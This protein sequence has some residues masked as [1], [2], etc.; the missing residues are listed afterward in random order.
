M[1]ILTNPAIQ[2]DNKNIR[3]YWNIDKHALMLIVT[4]K[5]D[6]K[7]VKRKDYRPLIHKANKS[8]ETLKQEFSR[9]IRGILNVDF[10]LDIGLDNTN[11]LINAIFNY[12]TV[13]K[14]ATE[15]LEE[16][17]NN[18][19]GHIF[20]EV[21]QELE[22]YNL[23][24]PN[25][26]VETPTNDNNEFDLDKILG[27]TAKNVFKDYINHNHQKEL[28]NIDHNVNLPQTINIDWD[29]LDIF[30]HDLGEMVINKPNDTLELMQIALAELTT[31]K[32][33][34]IDND[35]N[36][37][38]DNL[39]ITPTKHL[40]ASK[41]GQMVQTEGIIKGILEP[42]FYYKTAVFECKGCH[43]W[44]EV[45]QK[46]NGILEPSLC[47]ECGGRSFILM[48]E[49]STAIDL[50]YIRLQEPTEDLDTDERPRNILVC[51]TGSLSHNIVN[52]QRVKI[53][54]ILEGMDEDGNRKFVLNA[55]NIVNVKDTKIE[56]TDEDKQKIISLSKKDNILDILINS[57]APKIILPREVKLAVLCYLVK[58]GYTEDLRQEIHLLFIG[59]PGTAKTKLKIIA[60]MLAEKGIKTSGT[61]TSGVGLVGAVDRDPVLNVPMVNAGAMTMAHNGHLFIDEM[62]KMTKED[63]QKILDGME[64]GHVEI[65]KWGLHEELPAETSIFGIGNPVYGRFDQYKTINDQIKIYPALQSRFDI[66]F[67]LEDKPNKEKDTKIGYSILN[68]FRP[69]NKLI[70]DDKERID[71]DLLRKYLAYARDN[72]N[73]IPVESEE[74][75][76]F[77]IDYYLES[78][79]IGKDA[80]S[81]EA[82]NRF[83]GA[84][85]KLR[86]VNDINVEDYK[87]AIDMQNYSIKSLGMDPLNVD[88]DNMRG[89]INTKDKEHRTAIINIMNKYMQSAGNL[90]DDAIPK[91]MLMDEFMKQQSVKERT[92]YKA[93]K[94]LKDGKEIYE[95][96]NKVYFKH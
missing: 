82:V 34:D 87:E 6:N 65:T 44:Q 45:E 80:R 78:R 67:V 84:I 12:K 91:Q 74:L 11:K 56:I 13:D 15:V 86:L 50:K 9:E 2:H 57:L 95:Y 81:F 88:I 60:H 39:D 61:N 7:R 30:D 92:F 24:D 18:E 49:E 19:F 41:I 77:L 36:I 47:P 21:Q 43:R 8:D 68:S 14:P 72:Y 40:L 23:E 93:F 35:I 31:N 17:N 4:N 10:N 58:A 29:K 66:M 53:T 89:N 16:I 55:N 3:A 5:D 79:D 83:A 27:K 94:Q 75:D 20:H 52:G 69:G 62:E 70:E 1:E 46:H 96:D 73:P 63:S 25:P 26:N 32:S 71:H 64:S 90:D 51:L 76:K 85:A 38:F 37:R 59:D 42:S 28:W 22:E 48:P 33:I 54:G